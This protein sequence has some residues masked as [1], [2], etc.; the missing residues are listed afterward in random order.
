MRLQ[1]MDNDRF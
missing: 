1:F